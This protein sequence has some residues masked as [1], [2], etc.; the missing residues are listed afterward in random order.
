MADI[1]WLIGSEVSP[2]FMGLCNKA[3]GLCEEQGLKLYA[4]VGLR[5]LMILPAVC[6]KP[7]AQT[8]L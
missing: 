4:I 3:R 2:S 7:V 6:S 5:H 8:G 1:A